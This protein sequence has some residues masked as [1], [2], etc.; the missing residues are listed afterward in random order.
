MLFA[1]GVFLL[2][3]AAAAAGAV[4]FFW[5]SS[6]ILYKFGTD[7][8]FLRAGQVL[9]VLA[10][11]LVLFQLVL[12][13]R[14]RLLDRI[15]GLLGL[16]RAHRFVGSAAVLTALAHPILVLASEDTGAYRLTLEAWPKGVGAL[17]L[18]AA[19]GTVALALGRERLGIRY[20]WW[21]LGHRIGTPVLVVL[22]GLHAFFV[23]GVFARG[24]QRAGLA[25]LMAAYGL[26][27]LGV[28]MRP[29]LLRRRPYRVVRVEA[30]ARDAWTVTLEAERAPM[31][32]HLPGQFAFVRFR[33]GAVPAEEHPFTIA[34]APEGGDLGFTIRGSGDWTDRVGRLAPGD[35]ALVDGPYGRFTP[36]V[37][38]SHEERIFIAGG[39]GIT[40]FLSI[41][42]SMAHRKDKTGTT[43]LWSNRTEEDAPCRGEVTDL[44]GRIPA[45]R[46]V[47]VFTRNAP[48]GAAIARL[49]RTLLE[50]EV[51]EAC[52]AGALVF[53]C[54]PV[55]MMETVCR[56]L[57][58]MGTPARRIVT[59]AFRL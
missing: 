30:A 42:R 38:E 13:A 59:E 12:A 16:Y 22:L 34:S 35:R 41:L 46:V 11:F 26:L 40:P 1:A 2:A 23:E 44:E 56:S 14:I 53:V 5:E 39:V 21:A 52:R 51:G 3:A 6:S 32:R 19:A 4:P 45:L 15:Y 7:R 47:R 18:L 54:G 28:R 43:L 20:D 33:S 37:Q 27:W 29:L 57:R 9:G 55:P 25:V 48:E 24:P 49:G 36:I 50:R 58:E 10:G 8:V 17:L 31:P